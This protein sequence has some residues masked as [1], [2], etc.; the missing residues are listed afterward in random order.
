MLGSER[1]KTT[2]KKINLWNPNNKMTLLYYN[3]FLSL[4]IR[5]EKIKNNNSN[6]KN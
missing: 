3:K 1:K 4:V 2:D 6:N 5:R